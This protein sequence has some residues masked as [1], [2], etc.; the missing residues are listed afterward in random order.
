MKAPG[1]GPGLAG[2]RTGVETFVGLLED[3]YQG[4][5]HQSLLASPAAPPPTLHPGRTRASH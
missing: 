1:E 3:A 4:D 2:S 5:P